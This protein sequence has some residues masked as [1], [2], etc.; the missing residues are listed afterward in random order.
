M[1][2]E[3][4]LYER[5]NGKVKCLVCERSCVLE[6]GMKGICGN[7]VNID[8]RLFFVGYG[9]LSAVES[10]PIE[11]KPFFHYW[12]GSSALTFSNWGC[13]MLCPWCQN[14][15]LSFRHPNPDS[16]PYYSPEEVVE[17]ALKMGDEGVCASFNEPTTQLEYLI[18]VFE[19]AGKK[20]LY[21]CI[22]SNG[23]MSLRALRELADSGMTGFKVDVKGC[24]YS[25]RRFL[26]A[27]VEVV[28]RNARKA[29][30]LGL[31]VEIVF[32]VIPNVN[33]DKECIRWVIERHLDVLGSDI[34]LHINRYYPAFRFREPPTPI[35]LLDWAWRTARKEGVKYVYVGNVPGHPAEHTYCP[36]CGKTLILRSGYE[37]LEYKLTSD[38]R[39]PRCGEKIPIAGR[40]VEKRERWRHIF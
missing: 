37:I 34:P 28:F 24:E 3:A 2:R 12:P 19:L 36:G 4:L 33:A 31:H 7:R 5:R 13:N 27:D 26:G 29:L 6:P 18:D 1:F 22:V 10:R 30:N 32:L 11:I 25:Y 35:D 15:H 21:S 40:R 17:L 16:D 23:Y 14:W 8:G 9:R 39:C 20:G 38:N